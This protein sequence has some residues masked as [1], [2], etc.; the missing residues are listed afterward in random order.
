MNGVEQRSHV[1]MPEEVVEIPL[2]HVKQ[3]VVA[4]LG[5]WPLLE[6]AFRLHG[7]LDG[8]AAGNAFTVGGQILQL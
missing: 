3:E 6:Q 5:R 1:A 4:A 8:R 2:F 7:C